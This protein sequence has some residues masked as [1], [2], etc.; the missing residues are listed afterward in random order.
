M[1]TELNTESMV[2]TADNW[3][4]FAH[5]E[6]LCV[7][8][9]FSAYLWAAKNHWMTSNFQACRAD[10]FLGVSYLL[11]AMFKAAYLLGSAI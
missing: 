10:L 6:P 3:M 11:Y 8:L 7:A 9:I 5:I 4:H 2:A 1:T